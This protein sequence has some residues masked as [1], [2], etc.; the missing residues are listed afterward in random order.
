MRKEERD[1]SSSRQ[2]LSQLYSTT[3]HSLRGAF[4][5]CGRVPNP[6]AP[7]GL[8]AVCTVSAGSSAGISHQSCETKIGVIRF[9]FFFGGSLAGASV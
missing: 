3:K 5:G 4:R 1:G 2:A 7:R 6:E 9:A 8:R